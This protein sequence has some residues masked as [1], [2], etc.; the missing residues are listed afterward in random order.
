MARAGFRL[1]KLGIES[2]NQRTL[3]RIDKGTSVEALVRGCKEAKQVGLSPHLTTMIGYPW[4]TRDEARRTLDLARRLFA[5]GWADTIQ[6]TVVMP[7]PG[8][9][10]FAE[11]EREGWLKYGHEWGAVRHDAPGHA[12][13][14]PR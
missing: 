9:P 13:A 3:D 1:I 7:Y 11:A 10:L 6:A 12:L 2:A 4:E 5:D 14:D 8:T